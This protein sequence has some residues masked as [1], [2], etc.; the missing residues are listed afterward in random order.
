MQKHAL[1]QIDPRDNLIVSLT[2]LRR[3]T[4]AAVGRDTVEFKEDIPAK[5]KFALTDLEAGEFGIMYGIIVGRARRKIAAGGLIT[6][7][8]FEHATMEFEESHQ[9]FHW[10]PP[11]PYASSPTEFMGYRRPDAKVGTANY[12]N[13]RPRRAISTSPRNW[14]IRSGPRAGP[15]TPS[16]HSPPSTAGLNHCFPTLTGCGF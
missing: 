2:G 16:F 1:L 8:N 14:S 13:I 4:S 3:G 11:R 5:H 9:P 10:Q 12:W 7:D 15:S 6:T